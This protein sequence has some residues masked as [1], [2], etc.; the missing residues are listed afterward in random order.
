M[1]AK[2]SSKNSLARR[3]LKKGVRAMGRTSWVVHCDVPPLSPKDLG[4]SLGLFPDVPLEAG[5]SAL[6]PRFHL[7]DTGKSQ[8]L[9]M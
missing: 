3:V 4:S 8:G 6:I 1:A 5:L 2:A 9:A 7:L